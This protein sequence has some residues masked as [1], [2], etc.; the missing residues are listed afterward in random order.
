[1][2]TEHHFTEWDYEPTQLE[3]LV[4]TTYGCVL[5]GS[6]I[7]IQ[8]SSFIDE[9]LLLPQ[10]RGKAKYIE[11]KVCPPLKGGRD[12]Y[13]TPAAQG[14]TEALHI[15]LGQPSEYWAHAQ[16]NF[17]CIVTTYF[18]AGVLLLPCIWDTY[19]GFPNFLLNADA[20][21]PRGGS[22]KTQF[23]HSYCSVFEALISHVAASPAFA[24]ELELLATLNGEYISLHNTAHSHREALEKRQTRGPKSSR[25]KERKRKPHVNT[26]LDS[27]ADDILDATLTAQ[28]AFSLDFVQREVGALLR[29]TMEV[30]ASTIKGKLSKLQAAMEN[31][32]DFLLPQRELALSRKAFM[33]GWNPDALTVAGAVFSVAV[34][35][36]ILFNTL[37]L[38]TA[39]DESFFRTQFNM[40][41]D[42]EAYIADM[43]IKYRKDFRKDAHFFCNMKAYTSQLITQRKVETAASYWRMACDSKWAELKRGQLTFKKAQDVLAGQCRKKGALPGCGKLDQYLTLADLA[44]C[45]LIQQPTLWEVGVFIAAIRA[46]A[47]KGLQQLRYL[48]SKLARVGKGKTLDPKPV[49]KAFTDFYQDVTRILSEEEQKAMKWNVIMAEHTLC[50]VSRFKRM[51]LFPIHK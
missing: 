3:G 35:R 20:L 47:V 16:A 32:T 19:Q 27:D 22:S 2:A 41:T 21:T 42:F 18:G 45:G 31:K 34:H 9:R 23:Q 15:C 49:V 24:D 10:Y 28:P 4:V 50:K 29:Q 36:N 14:V 1:M 44:E 26:P 51:E 25:K 40:L 5:R 48:P 46:G 30:A 13:F 17:V 38:R 33:K 37:F 12:D 11:D 6:P 43:K 8:L 39:K 7:S